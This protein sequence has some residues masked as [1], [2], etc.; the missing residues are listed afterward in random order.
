MGPQRLLPGQPFVGRFG[1][2]RYQ[3]YGSAEYPRQPPF[4]TTLRPFY[5]VLGDRLLYGSEAISWIERRGRGIE[6]GF[7]SLD[8]VRFHGEVP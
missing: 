8:E 1:E 2:M 7:T 6:R 4:T 3:N 5:S